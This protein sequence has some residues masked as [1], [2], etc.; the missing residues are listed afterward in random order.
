MLA[1]RGSCQHM[2]TI[3]NRYL[4]ECLA[5][6]ADQCRV[7][8]VHIDGERRAAYPLRGCNGEASLGM[9]ISHHHQ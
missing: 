8:L 9:L 3:F 6:Q 1:S 4:V 7:A 5:H 2:T